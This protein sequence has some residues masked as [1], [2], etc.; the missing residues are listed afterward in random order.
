[1]LAACGNGQSPYEVE[2][3]QLRIKGVLPVSAS[4][5]ATRMAAGEQ[6]QLIDVR[7]PEEFA[8]GHIAGAVNFPVEGFDPASL[9]SANGRERILY[10]RTGKR[11]GALAQT[12]AES[13]GGTAIF[14]A[15][16]LEA[17]EKAGQP[18]VRP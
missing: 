2:P 8:V 17:W 11:S 14:M 4:A 15:G 9:P 7:T 13:T 5:L 10:C 16:G 3:A 18:L 1:M 6:F 12:L